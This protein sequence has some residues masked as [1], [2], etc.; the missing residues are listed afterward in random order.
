VVGEAIAR[1]ERFRGALDIA[2]AAKEVA[3]STRQL[4]RR[5][6]AQVGLSPKM[7]SRIRRFSGV[8]A[9]LGEPSHNWVGTAVSCG[10]WDQ[11]HLIRDC[12]KL[13]GITS[14]RLLNQ[15]ADLA[16]HFYRRFEQSHSALHR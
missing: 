11:A 15:D 2:M 9:A 1:I 10:Y 14:T 5:F 4:E 3:L 8:C 12:K 16:R 7:F 6:L 13:A